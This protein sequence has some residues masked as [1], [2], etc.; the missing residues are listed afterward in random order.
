MTNRSSQLQ[1][2]KQEQRQSLSFQ[3]V[4]FVRLLELPIE[5]L[6]ERV[7]AE[8]LENPALE[9]K[10]ETDTTSA[11]TVDSNDEG[12]DDEETY[13]DNVPGETYTNEV[14]EEELAALGD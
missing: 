3:Q 2:Q 14:D 4:Q 13:E 6:E 5:G 11:H 10:S 9:L 12:S 8:V 1:E 7:R